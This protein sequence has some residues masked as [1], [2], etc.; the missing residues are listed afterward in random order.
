LGKYNATTDVAINADFL[1]MGLDGPTALVLSGNNFFVA[2]YGSGTV[3]EYNATTGAAI[4]RQLHF[5]AGLP[6]DTRRCV[7][8]SLVI[9]GWNKRFSRKHAGKQP[10]LIDIFTHNT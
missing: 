4:K 2:N 5:R 7:T 6:L 9:D 1:I 10:H 8:A 3:G